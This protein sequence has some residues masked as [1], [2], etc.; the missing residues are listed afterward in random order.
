MGILCLFDWDETLIWEFEYSTDKY[1]LHH[2]A[3]ILPN[4]NIL[5]IAWEYKTAS[6]AIAMGRNPNF[7]HA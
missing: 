1:C 4:G 2:D 5:M 6:E 3:E 7:G